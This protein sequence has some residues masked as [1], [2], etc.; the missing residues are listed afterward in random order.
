MKTFLTTMFTILTLT[1]C[2]SSPLDYSAL[3]PPAQG[4]GV[5]FGRV[6]LIEDDK[7][8]ALSLLGESKFGLFVL[9]QNTS[10]AIYV[11]LK[12]DGTFI[13]H[14]P[15]GSYTI[16][17]FERRSYGSLTGRVFA[18]YRVLEDKAA[19]IGTLVI[20]FVGTRY[21]VGLVDEFESS[22]RVLQAR[23][24]DLKMEVISHLMHM[25]ESR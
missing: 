5:V 18:S 24:P 19:Y 13:W 23:A 6:K 25:E 9:P 15:A 7:E 16:A 21:W 12:D 2:A 1:G 14:Q 8:T 4:E 22:W 11:P 17:G 10:Q 3:N 20:T